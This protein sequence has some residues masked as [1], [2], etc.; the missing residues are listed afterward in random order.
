MNGIK[1]STLKLVEEEFS[2]VTVIAKGTFKAK[3]VKGEAAAE[4][5]ASGGG[6][7]LDDILPREDISKHLNSKLMK[8]FDPAGKDWKIK[9]K[10]CDTVE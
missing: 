3:E 9:V 4:M 5:A 1:D 8:M 10:A 2:K 6:A 7:N